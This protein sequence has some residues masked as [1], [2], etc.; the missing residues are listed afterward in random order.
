MLDAAAA[1]CSNY[2]QALTLLWRHRKLLMFV[3]RHRAYERGLNE[4]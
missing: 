3:R 1:A 4:E 2:K